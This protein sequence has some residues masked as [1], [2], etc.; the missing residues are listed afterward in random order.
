V[1]M[2]AVQIN[3]DPERRP[4]TDRFAGTRVVKHG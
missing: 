3:S 4:W 2:I 1:I